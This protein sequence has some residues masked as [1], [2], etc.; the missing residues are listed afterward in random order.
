MMNAKKENIFIL[1]NKF[2][3]FLLFIIY[4]NVYKPTNLQYGQYVR[5]SPVPNYWVV[6]VI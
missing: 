2:N 5:K 1:V 3:G 4:F 6:S